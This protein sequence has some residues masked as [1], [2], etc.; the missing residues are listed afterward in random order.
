VLDKRDYRIALDAARASY[1]MA[2]ATKSRLEKLYK[3]R[4]ASQSQLDEITAQLERAK[5]EMNKAGLNLE[6]CTITSPIGGIINNVYIEEGQYAN[7]GDPIAEIMQVDRVKVSVGI[8]ESDVRAVS[9]VKSYDVSI[10]ALGGKV[11]SAEKSFLSLSGDPAARL[12]RL[13]LA[14][15]NPE[16][17]IL[18]DMFARVDIVKREIPDAIT[19][20]LYSL[21]TLD[22]R[23][24]VYVV[25][26]GAAHARP[27]RTGIQEGWRIQVT[28]GL[29]PGDRLIVVGHR[30]V[31]NGQ[32]VNV[33]RTVSDAEELR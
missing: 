33:I 18:P 29:S 15:E 22:G 24:M 19:V 3:E 1:D 10:D 23:D 31:S 32:G 12:Y 17:E 6:R 5:A 11:F 13:E 28:E 14:I 30:R 9:R 4:F 7:I 27:V 16:G 21:V 8:P 20:P 25:N 26:N 2:L